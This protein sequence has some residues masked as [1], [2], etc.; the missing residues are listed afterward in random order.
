[1]FLSSI[2][3]FMYFDCTEFWFILVTGYIIYVFSAAFWNL[4]SIAFF[5][6]IIGHFITYFPIFTV[7]FINPDSMRTMRLFF[8]SASHCWV[9]KTHNDNFHFWCS[10]CSH[11]AD[12]V[13]QCCLIIVEENV[14]RVFLESYIFWILKMLQS[15]DSFE[16]IWF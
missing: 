7:E 8:T 12:Y 14:S 15:Y 4:K 11:S 2:F 5:S 13:Q 9:N 10:L 16:E 6:N 3:A 1:M